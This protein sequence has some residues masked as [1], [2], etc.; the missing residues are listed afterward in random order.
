MFPHR[1]PLC[2]YKATNC[3]C[4]LQ[5]NALSSA[6]IGCF[7]STVSDPCSTLQ[8]E[9]C[10]LKCNHV[11]LL[12]ACSVI[13]AHN[14]CFVVLLFYGFNN[15]P[16]AVPCMLKLCSILP[17]CWGCMQDNV[18]LLQIGDWITRVEDGRAK[19]MSRARPRALQHLQ[20]EDEGFWDTEPER[21]RAPPV[22]DLKE[23]HE[24]HAKP[25]ALPKVVDKRNLQKPRSNS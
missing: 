1:M 15:T 24:Y 12:L 8:S 2:G 11:C 14:N 4:M 19:A 3:A 5:R 16:S 23:A 25:L 13:L 18:N 20:E 10:K 9:W 21:R 22:L 17:V 7:A 6:R